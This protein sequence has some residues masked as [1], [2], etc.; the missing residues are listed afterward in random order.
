MGKHAWGKYSVCLHSM[1]S[2]NYI[3]KYNVGVGWD[4]W[5]IV[6]TSEL[7]GLSL[8]EFQP[9]ASRTKQSK[10]EEHGCSYSYSLTLRP[11]ESV[12]SF[13]KQHLLANKGS[14]GCY[15]ESVLMYMGRNLRL[16]MSE[17]NTFKYVQLKVIDFKGKVVGPFGMSL[18]RGQ[19]LLF[20]RLK[21]QTWAP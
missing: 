14:A 20:Q 1:F 12:G 8:G 5:Y 11:R 19:W 21:K 18:A 10:L 17:Q 6:D 2:Q 16:A 9:R 3:M 4:K 13:T 7:S 15:L